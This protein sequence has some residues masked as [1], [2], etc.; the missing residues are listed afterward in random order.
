MKRHHF[1][2]LSFFLLTLF[3]CSKED[4]YL[5]DIKSNE[6]SIVDAKIQDQVGTPIIVNTAD[7]SDVYMTIYGSEDALKTAAPQLAVS[8]G[9]TMDPASGTAIDF[10]QSADHSAVYKVTSQSGETR[11]WTVHLA[12]FNNPYEGTW[13]IANYEFTWDDGY[14]WGN[15]GA[16]TVV[17]KFPEI[18]PG[19]DDV[20]TFGVLSGITDAGAVYGSYERDPGP[21]GQYASYI[22]TPSG[23]DWS[24]K[25]DQLPEGKGTYY[26]N[27]NNSVTITMEN[28][29]SYT[30]PGKSSFDGSTL[31]YELAPGDFDWNINWNDYYGDNQ[32]KFQFVTRL[33]YTL[34]KQ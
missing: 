22:Y 33:W 13:T 6:R 24:F 11:E 15:A 27:P 34:T 3:S 32:N 12:M 28:G 8:Y 14:G 7:S 2:I 18:A 23:K 21:D 4:Y 1:I 16:S 5:K 19:L 20:I 17:A 10:S 31:V 30:M 9:A 25:F 29:Q 26:I